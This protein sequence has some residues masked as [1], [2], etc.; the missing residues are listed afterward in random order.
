MSTSKA[1]DR[2]FKSNWLHRLTYYKTG[3]ISRFEAGQMD[4]KTSLIQRT[5]MQEITAITVKNLRTTMHINAWQVR[6]DR[7]TPFG[8]PF[9]LHSEKERQ[10]VC[11]KY[12]AYFY[13]K[14]KA[15]AKFKANVDDLEKIYKLYGK[16]EL[17]CWC[18]PKPC[19]ADIIRLYLIKKLT[20]KS[21]VEENGT[22]KKD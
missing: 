12:H 20:D 15:N 2:W 6:V 1:K 10:D 8:N 21:E 14:L 11:D 22:C 17:L 3:N 7:G 13:E 4:R 16:L 19:H 18:A 5:Y 9:K